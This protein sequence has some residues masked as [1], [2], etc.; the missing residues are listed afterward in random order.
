MVDF[1]YQFGNERH[2]VSLVRKEDH[3]EVTI[4]GRTYIAKAREIKQGFFQLNVDG[5]LHKCCVA[6]DGTQRHVFFDSQVFRLERVEQARDPNQFAKISGDIKSPISGKVVA[7]KATEGD[8]VEANQVLLIIE[9]MKME[10]QI[11][12][13]FKGKVAKSYHKEKDQ[14]DIGARLVDVKEAE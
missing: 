2:S 10:Y 6:R 1:F 14:V 7:V 4:K 5:A 12:S 13:P 8:V 3:F 11:K 9:A